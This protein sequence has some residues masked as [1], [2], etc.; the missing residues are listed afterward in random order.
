MD[1]NNIENIEK[2]KIKKMIKNLSE[3]KGKGTS[4]I[5]L[6]IPPGEQISKISKMLIEEYCTASNIKSKV[7]KTS[8]LG[9]IT[10]A[11]MRLKTYN[12]IPNNGLVIYVGI[13]DTEKGEKR[14]AIDFEPFKQI[15]TFLYKCDNVFHVEILASLLETNERYGMIVV[16]GDGYLLG[17]ISG[18]ITE[19]ILKKYVVLPNKHNKG[20]QSALRFAR[21]REEAIH[22]YITKVAEICNR[23]YIHDNKLNVIGVIF[24]G[25]ADI[26]N[27]IAQSELLDKKIRDKILSVIDI[28]Y[29]D[30]KGFNEAIG[31]CGDIFKNVELIKEKEILREY[32]EHIAKDTNKYC[33]GIFNTIKLLK[34][35][36]IEKLIVWDKLSI[37][38][39]P[40]IDEE[41]TEKKLLIDWLIDNYPKYGSNIYIISNNTTE[42]L[43][44]EKGFGGIGGILRY[45]YEL[46]ETMNNDDNNNNNKNDVSN[47]LADGLLADGLLVDNLLVD[48]LLVDDNDNLLDDDNDDLFM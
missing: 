30:M 10:S 15:N 38:Y 14:V 2:Y 13:I 9:A 26:K 41:D 36:V 43:Q 27:K 37:T 44:F 20:G 3:A 28:S 6:L 4:M 32:F 17:I 24:A 5:S 23:V 25:K 34:L 22:N 39:K 16:D 47:L 18:N 46:P 35:G 40:N 1:T 48:N 45:I 29:G 42:G 7:N 19:V 33:Y 11:Q 31:K 21:M 8:V 12:K